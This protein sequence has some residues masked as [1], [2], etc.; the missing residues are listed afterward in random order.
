[1]TPTS[2][3]DAK[4]GAQRYFGDPLSMPVQYLK[5]IGPARARDLAKQGIATV[6]DLIERV[7]R[8]YRDYS[9]IKPIA[10]AQNGQP[11]SLMGTVVM[12]DDRRVRGNLHLTR[13][14][15]SDG[16]GTAAGV[17]FNQPWQAKRFPV[18]MKVLF[19]GTVE[20]RGA[21]IQITNP[22]WEII[23]E[24]SS[25]DPLHAGRIVPVYP[26]TGGLNPRDVRR[27]VYLALQTAADLMPDTI[28]GPV[29]E[30]QGLMPAAE[31]WRAIHFPDS[32]GQRE[33]ARATLAFEE[34]FVLQVGLALVRRQTVVEQAG[35]AHGPDGEVTRRLRA[36]LPFRLT[37]AQERVI[38]QVAADMESSRPMN[39]LVQGDV[40]SG[41]TMVAVFALA[42]AVDSGHQGALMAPTEI[43]AEQ[44]YLNL[45]RI[46]APLGVEVVLV[47]G[48]LT[49]KER[50]A[51]LG[52]LQMG[53]AHIA[54]GTHALIEDRVAFKDLSLV[55]TDEQ[56]RFG[57]RQ[58]ARLQQK[59]EVMPDTLVMTATPIPRTLALTLYG[60]LDVSV[61]DELPP[62]RRPVG[63]Y[64]RPESARRQVYD[65]LMRTEVPA[66]RQ[67]YVV[68]PLIEESDKLQAQAATEW[69][70][71]LK[72]QYPDV[73][74][75]LLHGRL[76]PAE[77]E[78]VMEAFRAGEIQVL[79]TTTVI[80]VG[81]DVP[82][83]TMMIIEGADR[84][85]L[86]QLHQLRGRVGRGSH[87]SYCVLIADP[88]TAEAR[89]RLM[90]MQKYSDGFAL[91]EKDLELR[92]PGEFFGTRQH[93]MPDLKVAN[94]IADLAILERARAE[95][96]RLV[97]EDPHL[98]LPEHQALRQAVKERLGEQFGFILVS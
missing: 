96:M 13:V 70:E 41:K 56:H 10:Q 45:R 6:R 20:R 19:A 7:P 84:F 93:G 18:G 42:K 14:I 58:R 69:Y 29:R 11:E 75:G 72:A 86:A 98:R 77:K 30:R 31:A 22:E 87:Q 37:A 57:V 76:R 23:D 53:A 60:D 50:D 68:C 1:M 80:E 9:Q 48:S 34:L 15:I 82:N 61:I 17:W 78:A 43:L 89:E 16:S 64:W 26:L 8:A 40:G 47:S 33:R 51:N 85:G 71:R 46:F 59:G 62:G 39:R 97:E 32:G 91:A 65:H 28:P 36:G 3:G 73:R 79:V 83:A 44:H 55:I 54:V 63:T 4:R 66:G 74:L 95:A 5:G 27:A 94:P 24:E 49:K 2:G 81:V 52:L 21:Q 90:I 25:S 67:G 35:I 88:K 38:R 12:V 92:G